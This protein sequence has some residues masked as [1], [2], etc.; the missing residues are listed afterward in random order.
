MSK[1]LRNVELINIGLIVLSIILAFIIPFRLFL[2]AYAVLGS[3]HFVT[4]INWLHDRNYFV[5]DRNFLPIGLI[6]TG[7]IILPKALSYAGFSGPEWIENI[8][9]LIHEY[10]NGAIFFCLWASIAMTLI[11]NRIGRYSVVVLGIPLA[12]VL[13]QAPL[14]ILIIGFLIPTLLHVYVFTG[15]FM[16]FGALKSSS[17]LG[18]VCVL[19]LLVAPFLF[20]LVEI[21][22][23]FYNIS[24]FVKETI[25]ANRFFQTNIGLAKMLGISDGE[26]FYFYGAWELKMQAF[27]TF[28]YLY[29]YLNW[30]SKTAIIGWHVKLKGV[31][32]YAIISIWLVLVA[33]FAIDYRFGFFVSLGLSFAHV[34]LEFP[35][36][37]HSIKG[38]LEQSIKR[39]TK[40]G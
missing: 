35:L 6:T 31:R 14:Y 37:V 26:N 29:H 24:D 4:E 5:S 3:L 23:S 30:F 16:A 15:L 9:L 1:Q 25:I 33:A 18:Y 32:F 28:A 22:P 38:I 19:M 7:L 13:N 34:L 10:S 40:A 39:L 21:P 8:L 11:P 27:I 20:I 17:K 36:N 2:I 12:V